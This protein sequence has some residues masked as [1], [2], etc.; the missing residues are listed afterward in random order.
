MSRL[1]K[2]MILVGGILFTAFLLW[3]IPVLANPFWDRESGWVRVLQEGKETGRYSMDRDKTI[4]ILYGE[5]NYN[6]VSIHDGQVSVLEADCPDGL[7][8][9][10][11]EISR[12][13]ESIICLPHRLVLQ[14][15]SGREGETDAVAY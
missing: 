4:R 7:C 12:N 11:K 2:D 14:I 13:G 1:K 3:L 15:S 9:S 8:I 5:K 10:Q 6:L